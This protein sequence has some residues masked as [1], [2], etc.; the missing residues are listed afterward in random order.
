MK[1][2]VL[3]SA[4]P[5]RQELLRQLGLEFKIDGRSKEDPPIAGLEPSEF[6]KKLSL[7]KA[8]L[9]HKFHP[10]SL[11]IA[12]DTI[13]VVS[14][15]IIGKPR[16]YD[17]ARAMLTLLSGKPHTVFTGFTILDTATNRALSKSVATTVYFKKLSAEEINAYIATGEPMDKAGAYAIQG[18]G[19]LLVERI[20]GDYFNV[21]G[22][23]LFALGEALKEFGVKII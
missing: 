1:N 21:V 16:S 11:I 12:A 14:G 10:N 17:D 5:R 20:E 13:G 2:I 4:S 9:I 18:R 8:V 23:P 7:E 6:V 15:R 22:L 19:A 3:A